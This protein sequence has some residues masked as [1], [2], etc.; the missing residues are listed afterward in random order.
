MH[1]ANG[2]LC[3]ARSFALFD[4]APLVVVLF[5]FRY[6]DFDLRSALL[7]VTLRNDERHPFGFEFAAEFVDLLCVEQE[8]AGPLFFVSKCR[9]GHLGNLQALDPSFV[10][11]V[12]VDPRVSQICGMIAQASRLAADEHEARFVPIAE[13]VVELSS[14]VL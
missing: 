14:T 12:D 11:R 4:R 9:V 3:F 6:R 10:V 5:A 8:L 13:F 1:P 2:G 7:E